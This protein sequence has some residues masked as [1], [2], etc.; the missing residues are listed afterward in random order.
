MPDDQ[1]IAY[2]DIERSFP[3]YFTSNANAGIITIDNPARSDDPPPI[4]KLMKNGRPNNGNAAATEL[5]KKSFP[6]RM[7]AT[8][9]GYETG[10][11]TNALWKRRKI[12]GMYKPAPIMGAIQ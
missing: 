11:Y 1:C 6:A 4:P 2:L 3:P 9:A 5:R 7:L 10:K 8:Y 12:P